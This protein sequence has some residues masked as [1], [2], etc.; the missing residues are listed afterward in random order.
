MFTGGFKE[1][2]GKSATLLEDDPVVFSAFLQWVYGGKRLAPVIMQPGTAVPPDFI[3]RIELYGFAEKY[4]ITELTDYIMTNIMSTL[5]HYEPDVEEIVAAYENTRSKSPLRA[6]MSDNLYFIAK[7][8]PEESYWS[9]SRIGDG[10]NR[11]GDLATD[12]ILL[13]KKHDGKG[14]RRPSKQP[15]CTY[16]THAEGAECAFKDEI[17]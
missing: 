15:K 9:S 7:V 5:C 2:K 13:F 17:L 12:F 10:I 8:A 11:N 3:P 6:F 1:T 14:V 4:C 16:H